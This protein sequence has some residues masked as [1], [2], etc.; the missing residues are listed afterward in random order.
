MRVD[1]EAFC[2][3]HDVAVVVL[4]RNRA[5]LLAKRTD[6]ILDGYKLFYSGEGYEDYPYHCDERFEVPRGLHG[7]SL[8]RNYVLDLL[9]HKT[10][11]FFDD[12]ITK[13][14]W[15]SGT[16]SIPLD[17]EAIALAII[18]MVVH[19]HDQGSIAFG[20]SPIDIRKASPLNPFRLRTVIGTVL[21]VVG[22]EV[23]FDERNVLKTDY[24]FCLESMKKARTVHMD[25]RYFAAASKDAEAGG[26][27]EFRTQERRLRE[28]E[29]LIEWWGDDVIIPR[30]NKGNESLGVK[31]P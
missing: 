26:N 28:I 29:N 7:L 23:R 17:R 6:L 13:V 4:S 9:P 14:Y 8:V 19:A 11:L 16:V 22:R 1:L 18:D 2:R 27:N 25:M 31:V 5:N 3:D 24:D 20:M 21:G 12:D 10:V 15:V 30:D